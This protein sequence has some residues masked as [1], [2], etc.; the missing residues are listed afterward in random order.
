MSTIFAIARTTLL[1]LL[2]GKV[3]YAVFFFAVLIVAASSL[4]GS[5]TVGDQVLIMKDFGLFTLSLASVL[6]SVIGG[7]TLLNKELSRKTIYNILAKPVPRS[8]FLIGKYLGMWA[9]AALLLVLMAVPL[10]SVLYLVEH[11]FD[12]L[13][14][15][16]ILY[17]LLELTIVCACAIFFSAIVVT[18]LLSGLFTFGGFLAGRSVE[19]LLYFL[20][21]DDLS[22]TARALIHWAYYALPQLAKL[23]V[24]NDVVFARAEVLGLDRLAF[25]VVYSCGYSI[26][27]LALATIFFRR[28]EFN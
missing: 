14:V 16:A 15:V 28:K 20:R 19:Y 3:L 27:L 13:L 24:A 12:G 6:F 2:R 21:Q 22:A 5:V 11:R 23:N 1:E 18:P 26:A 8:Y 17:N 9:T 7:A 10:L 25:S 4:F